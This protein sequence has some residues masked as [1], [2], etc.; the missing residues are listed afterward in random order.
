MDYLAEKRGKNMKN[1]VNSGVEIIRDE[2]TK[3]P[4]GVK[5]V[6][7]DDPKHPYTPTKVEEVFPS[8]LDEPWFIEIVKD[9]THE[10]SEDRKYRRHVATSLD[11]VDYEGEWF[12]DDTPTPDVFMNIQEEEDR[13]YAFADTL[14]EINRRRFMLM[15]DDPSLSFQ[16]IA[17]MENTS[18]VAIFKSFK[19]IREKYLE[20]FAI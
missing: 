10:K 12:A 6:Y 18:K 20:F 15:Y 8:S 7:Y 13:V 4:I 19:L 17:D 5:W 2:N 11:D 14:S 16:D 1:A 3:E 9:I